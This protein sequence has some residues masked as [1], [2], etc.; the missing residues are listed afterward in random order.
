MDIVIH[1]RGSRFFGL[2]PLGL[3]PSRSEIRGLFRTFYG[4]GAFELSKTSALE[5]VVFSRVPQSLS[6]LFLLGFGLSIPESMDL[7]GVLSE[8]GAFR[9]S[10]TSA[11][12]LRYFCR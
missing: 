11:L 6:G 1:N 10:P 8:V 9:L 2:P 7:S 3:G 12:G 4:V 5:E